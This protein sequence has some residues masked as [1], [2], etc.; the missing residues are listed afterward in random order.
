MSDPLALKRKR[1]LALL[2]LRR[3]QQQEA[4]AEP[5]VGSEGVNANKLDEDEFKSQLQEESKGITGWAKTKAATA[6]NELS[7]VGI[8]KSVSD[9]GVFGEAVKGEIFE[10]LGFGDEKGFLQR[11]DEEVKKRKLRKEFTRSQ[12]GLASETAKIVGTGIGYAANLKAL[13]GSGTG[14]AFKFGG[15][16]VKAGAARLAAGAA[17]DTA[18]V[19][20]VGNSIDAL[21]EVAQGERTMVDALQNAAVETAKTSAVSGLTGAAGSFG[22]YGAGYLG[23]AGI[24]TA[25]KGAKFLGK[26]AMKNLPEEGALII[27]KARDLAKMGV[28]HK[29]AARQALDGLHKRAVGLYGK[30]K[31]GLLKSADGSELSPNIQQ[32]QEGIMR[33][34]DANAALLV[35][36]IKSKRP[37]AVVDN[38]ISLGEVF[39]KGKNAMYTSFGQQFD[40]IA[41]GAAGKT[42]KAEGLID[43]FIEVFIQEGSVVRAPSGALKAGNTKSAYVSDALAYLNKVK[44][45]NELSFTE[46]HT[47]MRELG[48][49]FESKSM[50]KE[51]E[52]A[53]QF[54]KQ[55]WGKFRETI[56]DPAIWGD[57]V[58]QRANY[59]SKEYKQGLEYIGSLGKNAQDVALTARGAA[60]EGTDAVLDRVGEFRS[61]VKKVKDTANIF[62][63]NRSLVGVLTEDQV[64]LANTTMDQVMET[65]N[66]N[67]LANPQRIKRVANKVAKGKISDMKPM[68]QEIDTM[69]SAFDEYQAVKEGI[70]QSDMVGVVK[71]VLL[72]PFNKN[73]TTKAKQ[74]VKTYGRND[75]K[76]AANVNKYLNRASK[77]QRLGGA[78][79]AI[80]PTEIIKQFNNTFPDQAVDPGVAYVAINHMGELSKLLQNEKVIAAYLKNYEG[81]V[82]TFFKN[83]LY[84]LGVAGALGAGAEYKGGEGTAWA[85]GVVGAAGIIHLMKQPQAVIQLLEQADIKLTDQFIEEIGQYAKTLAILEA[86]RR[87]NQTEIERNEDGR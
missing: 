38:L 69:F 44:N 50:T 29:Q 59:L 57:D 14:V 75:P 31:D 37:E 32:L 71:E 61:K 45:K 8:L 51:G 28:K 35:N 22:L 23:K 20:G 33:D 79:D 63:T 52:Q 86:K 1:A 83:P 21:H 64:K 72:D 3:Q 10:K 2:K 82:G 68:D 62:A 24:L 56:S 15:T 87:T 65:V 80:D 34:V 27:E 36:A 70:R 77:F 25:K 11:Y 41:Q 84:T 58:A 49:A 13:V 30:V 42:V 12:K 55:T 16:G 46:L 39:E 17:A 73:K 85:A 67:K 7:E 76:L 40:D 78:E 26:R 6:F 53:I 74:W 5:E 9:I 54:A 66:L 48:G 43:D 60:Q 47:M 19:E 4:N 18:I 81:V